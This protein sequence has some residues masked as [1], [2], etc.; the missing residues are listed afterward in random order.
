M[1]IPQ[2][3]LDFFD[4]FAI[5]GNH[6]VQY[7]MRGRVLRAYIDDQIALFRCAYFFYHFINR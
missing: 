6:Q 3:R 1:D 7:T 2:V 4:R 5:E